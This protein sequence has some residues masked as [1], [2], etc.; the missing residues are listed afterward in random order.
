M[1]QR[2]P[3]PHPTR[4]RQ[5]LRDR[6]QSPATDRVREHLAQCETCRAV[7]A[8]LESESEV[9]AQH[10]LV[11][12]S[13]AQSDQTGFFHDPREEVR[14]KSDGATFKTIQITVDSPKEPADGELGFQ[15][16]NATKGASLRIAS[17]TMSTCEIAPGGDS[18]TEFIESPNS[19]TLSDSGGA[20]TI[21]SDSITTCEI[22]PG[23]DKDTGSFELPEAP[24]VPDAFSETCVLEPGAGSSRTGRSDDR[25]APPCLTPGQTRFRARPSSITSAFPVTTFWRSWAG[26]AWAWCTRPVTGACI[27]WSRSRW[28]W[29]ARTS[30]RWGWP[31][32]VPRRRLLQS[33]RMRTSCKSTRPASTKGGRISRS[34]W[35]REAAS[36]SGFSKARAA[37]GQRPG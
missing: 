6:A 21:K 16:T 24:A 2:T 15:V 28:C 10:T 30:A 32:F 3:C 18:D 13:V 27:V 12:E 34:S 14:L 17:D 35:W 7:V 5:F 26:V 22:L 33:F 20:R 31:G 8:R 9:G 23:G 29:P 1:G 4:L 19:P 37:H 25:F 36:T 11:D